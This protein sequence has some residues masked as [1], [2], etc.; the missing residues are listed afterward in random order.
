MVSNFKKL[1]VQ[2]KALEEEVMVSRV[3]SNEAAIRSSN[4]QSDLQS[5]Y[6]AMSLACSAL[7][8][9]EMLELKQIEMKEKRFKLNLN[10]NGADLPSV[11]EYLLFVRGRDNKF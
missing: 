7:G 1:L 8:D 6:L 10:K 4:A 5:D 3:I 9:E 11:G 2:S